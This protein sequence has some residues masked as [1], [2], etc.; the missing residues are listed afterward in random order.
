MG[1]VMLI[2]DYVS[3]KLNNATNLPTS[4][5]GWAVE[6]SSA[7]KQPP[8]FYSAKNLVDYKNK[9]E[10]GWSLAYRSFDAGA[11][12]AGAG[13]FDSQAICTPTDPYSTMKGTDN[14]KGWFAA[15]QYTVA[16]NV[17]W[18]VEGQFLKIKNRGLATNLASNDLG[19]TYMTKLE[20]FY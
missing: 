18:T 4:P 11:V 17:I 12:P 16:K 1:N 20:F 9:G 15:V 19:K 3:T 6:L 10:F 14:N 7:T 5:K 2:A 13:G 8:I